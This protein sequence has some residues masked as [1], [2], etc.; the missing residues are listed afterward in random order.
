MTEDQI[1]AKIIRHV[2]TNYPDLRYCLF[3]IPN[4]GYRNFAEAAKFKAIGVLAGVPDLCLVHNGQAYFFEVKTDKGK[5]S[6]EQKK[7]H[8][9]WKEKG[10]SIWVVRSVEEVDVIIRGLLKN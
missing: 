3:H 1:Q 8:H 6:I 5:L 10:I 2:W 9:R 7:I 4:G